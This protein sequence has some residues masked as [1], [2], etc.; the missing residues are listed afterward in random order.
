MRDI[1]VAF[2]IDGTLTDPYFILDKVNK[3]CGLSLA[4]SDFT[5]YNLNDI[6]EDLDFSTEVDGHTLG[7]WFIY[8]PFDLEK[9]KLIKDLTNLGINVIIVT[10]RGVEGTIKAKEA[11]NFLGLGELPIYNSTKEETKGQILAKLKARVMVEDSPQEA[12]EIPKHAVDVLLLKR[13][14][15]EG[16]KL[17]GASYVTDDK[18]K[19]RLEGMLGISIDQDIDFNLIENNMVEACAQRTTCAYCPHRKLCA[20]LGIKRATRGISFLLSEEYE[21]CKTKMKLIKKGEDGNGK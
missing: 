16:L 4:P 12:M 15:N 2:D 19:E 10:A 21:R 1:I 9:I 17:E 14:Y 18:L 13:Y 8:S 7:E 5:K 3:A 20:W 11:L 6:V